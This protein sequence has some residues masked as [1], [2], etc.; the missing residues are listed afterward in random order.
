MGNWNTQEISQGKN[1]MKRGKI[2]LVFFLLTGLSLVS[3]RDLFLPG[4]FPMHDDTQPARVIEITKALRDGQFPVRVVRDLGYG[5]GYPLF[6]F[7]A[8]LPYYAGAAAYLAGFDAIIA[9][10]IMM[11]LGIVLAGFSMCALGIVFW[12]LPG[13][14]VSSVLYLYFPYH[15]IQLYVR[16]AVGELYAYA[17]L[18]LVVLGL[19]WTRNTATKKKGFLVSVLSLSGV[20]LS[21]TIYGYLV[22]GIMAAAVAVRA[23][24]AFVRKQSWTPVLLWMLILLFAL[25]L[26]ASF[27]LPAVFEMGGTAVSKVVGAQAAV[28]ADHFVCLPQLWHSEWGFGGSSPGCVDGMSFS[29]GKLHIILFFAALIV[30]MGT[31]KF[32][33]SYGKRMIGILAVVAASIFFV[34]PQSGWIWSVIPKSEFVQYPWRLLPIAGF[35]ISLATGILAVMGK[36]KRWPWIIATVIVT[37]VLVT[38]SDKFRIQYPTFASATVFE[39]GADISWRVSK[40]SDEYLPKG[41]RVPENKAEIASGLVSH[42]PGVS[43][44]VREDKSYRF[45]FSLSSP[46]KTT[47]RINRLFFPGFV[48]FVNGK[49]TGPA[50][51]NGL[52]EMVLSEGTSEVVGVLGDTPIRRFANVLSLVTAISLIILAYAKKTNA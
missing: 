25:D 38:Q 16:G 48:Y 37:M 52:P 34:L 33:L 41:F 45:A 1:I 20:I 13:A 32:R 15:A 35:G 8:P 36:G 30:G 23:C 26:S 39:S 24:C 22:V 47:I 43:V 51:V 18:P 9:T 19:Y 27:W 28:L 29:L 44:A 3:V 40:I 4:L 50:I 12:G 42:D 46:A 5:Y 2:L 21:H 11:G 31:T 14:L 7:Y 10:K 49:K 17:F 6:E